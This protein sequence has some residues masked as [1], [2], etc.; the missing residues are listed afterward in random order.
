MKF[1]KIRIRMLDGRYYPEVETS[2]LWFKSWEGI[3]YGKAWGK[4]CGFA[5]NSLIE[6]KAAVD[7]YKANLN[8]NDTIVHEEE[9]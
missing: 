4:Y 2:W 6:A 8:T 7:Q 3:A 9:I 1:M 5:Y